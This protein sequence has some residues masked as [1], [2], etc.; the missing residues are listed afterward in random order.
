MQLEGTIIQM[1]YLKQ[2]QK[3]IKK[4]VTLYSK[5]GPMHIAKAIKDGKTSKG[6]DF[7]SLLINFCTQRKK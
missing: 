2:I 7:N 6:I 4:I 5:L 3:L 1:N